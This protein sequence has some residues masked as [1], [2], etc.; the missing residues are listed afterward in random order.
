MPKFTRIELM[1]EFLS[2]QAEPI[3]PARKRADSKRTKAS[4]AATIQRKQIRAIK[5][6]SN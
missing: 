2:I 1:N 5:Y 4:K 3:T 6:G